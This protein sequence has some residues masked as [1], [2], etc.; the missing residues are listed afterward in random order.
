MLL[1]LVGCA[2]PELQAA[3]VNPEP[4]SF[5]TE[6]GTNIHV[7]QTGWVAVK[8]RFRELRSPSA[9]RVASI[10]TDRKWTEWM[11]IQFFVIEHPEGIVVFDTGETA[12]AHNPDYF[13]CDAGTRWFY[14]NQLRF[15]VNP[16]D[17]LGPQLNKIGLRPEDVKGTVMSHLH[18][19]HMGGLKYLTQSEVLISRVDAQGH[20]GALLCRIPDE[21]RPT[22][23]DYDGDAFGAFDASYAVTDD[24]S[25]RIV[26]TPGHTP[27]H[28]S[29]LFQEGEKYY[30]IAGD[31]IFDLA[32]LQAG[33]ALAGIV[34]DVDAARAS[35]RRIERQVAAFDTLL[36]PAH[37]NRVRHR[38]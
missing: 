37:D 22:L 10:V 30:F 27:G 23:V 7:I 3:P 35:I 36:A 19:D 14:L 15:A 13:D 12:E 4:H 17:E 24:G 9:L 28:Q 33:K 18:S 5:Q 21:I 8:E 25:I 2:Q 6:A 26:P 11:P 32:R 16:E 38:H 1:S 34:E 29:L 20:Q 31:A